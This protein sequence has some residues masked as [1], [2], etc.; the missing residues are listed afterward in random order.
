MRNKTLWINGLLS[1]FC[2]DHTLCVCG[3]QMLVNYQLSSFKE[4]LDGGV[5][6]RYDKNDHKLRNT[7]SL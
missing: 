4:V 2:Y 1:S 6:D 7:K 5:L 3:N